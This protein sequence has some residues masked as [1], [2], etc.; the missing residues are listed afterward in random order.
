MIALIPPL[1]FVYINPFLYAL[2][3]VHINQW[4][5]PIDADADGNVDGTD[6]ALTR[7]TIQTQVPVH[8]L[9]SVGHW[10]DTFHFWALWTGKHNCSTKNTSTLSLWRHMRQKE[11]CK[12][13]VTPL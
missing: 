6:H 7:A 8:C 10:M 4:S 11:M 12:V 13:Q 2:E 9:I 1:K 3:E 5:D